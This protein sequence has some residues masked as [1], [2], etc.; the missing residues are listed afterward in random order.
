MVLIFISNVVIFTGVEENE[1]SASEYED[2]S[3]DDESDDDESDDTI[4]SKKTNNNREQEDKQEEEQE[5]K[6]QEEEQ[7]EEQDEE[8]EKEQ[9]EEQEK[10]EPPLAIFCKYCPHCKRIVKQIENK[11]KEKGIQK[12]LREKVFSRGINIEFL[13]K[14]I[15]SAIASNDKL[16]K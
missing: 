14:T 16:N 10:E 2:E 13:K 4:K 11:M 8:Q 5:D 12:P 6:K 1:K 15:K 9:E 7:D 3:D